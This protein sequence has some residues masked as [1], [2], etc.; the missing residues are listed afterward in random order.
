MIASLAAMGFRS[1]RWLHPDH[2]RELEGWADQGGP[3]ELAEGLGWIWGD[4]G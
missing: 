1:R 3:Q 2:P 4:L